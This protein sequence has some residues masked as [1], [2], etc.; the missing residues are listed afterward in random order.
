MFCGWVATLIIGGGI[1]AGLFAQGIYSPSL[2]AAKQS[3]AYQTG[4]AADANATLGQLSAAF[5]NNAEVQAQQAAFA[6]ATNTTSP[7]VWPLSSTPAD[8]VLGQ[9]RQ[10]T[11]LEDSLMGAAAGR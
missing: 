4:I 2:P 8:M 9:A 7:N 6:M 5:P 3:I 10:V 1:S 11:A